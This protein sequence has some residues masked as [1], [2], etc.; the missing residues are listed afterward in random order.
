MNL[1]P[2]CGLKECSVYSSD[3]HVNKTKRIRPH[4]KKKTK[5]PERELNLGPPVCEP[6]VVPTV[7]CGSQLPRFL[8]STLL[9]VIQEE[10]YIR[11]IPSEKQTKAEP[12]SNPN[13]NLLF[14]Y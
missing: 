4:M 5:I 13:A 9:Y 2:F 11:R 3:S 1:K 8:S 6:S 10:N 14:A 12:D 7:L